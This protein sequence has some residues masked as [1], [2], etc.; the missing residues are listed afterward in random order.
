MGGENISVTRGVVSRR[1]APRNWF[2]RCL[3]IAAT[4]ILDKV[5][6][7]FLTTTTTTDYCFLFA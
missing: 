1:E 7:D 6:P 3:V 4:G 2:G 5:D